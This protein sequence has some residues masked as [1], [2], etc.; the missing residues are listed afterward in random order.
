M[1]LCLRSRHSCAPA[2]MHLFVLVTLHCVAV[3]TSITCSGGGRWRRVSLCGSRTF[4]APRECCSPHQ[5][6]V[7][8]L[9]QRPVLRTWR[10]NPLLTRTVRS[11]RS[12]RRCRPRTC[13][14]C[15]RSE[16]RDVAFHL[17]L[18]N[19]QP[20][21]CASNQIKF[22][23][24]L[25]ARIEVVTCPPFTLRTEWMNQREIRTRHNAPSPNDIHDHTDPRRFL[26]CI[27]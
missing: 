18:S 24:R 5:L 22:A 16:E 8:V 27:R 25:F 11:R 23:A 7:G 17:Q 10:E 26:W 2:I 14:C 6:A 15:Q 4:S 3:S 19:N 20:S 21:V 9:R 12:D 13:S 1:F